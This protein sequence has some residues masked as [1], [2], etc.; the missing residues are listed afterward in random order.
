VAR[1]GIGFDAF[2]V[3]ERKRFA[4]V[5][6]APGLQGRRAKG[7]M[8]NNSESAEPRTAARAK[9]AS[10]AARAV[11]EAILSAVPTARWALER[12]REGEGRPRSERAL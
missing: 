2:P 4:V 5:G 9:G 10:A 8:A 6:H 7:V 1:N 11:H 3:G 12:Q